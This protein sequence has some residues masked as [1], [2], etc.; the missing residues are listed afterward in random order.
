MD[1]GGRL[2][3]YGAG[4]MVAFGAAFAVA[5]AVAPGEAAATWAEKEEMNGHTEDAGTAAHDTADAPKGLSLS[6]DGFTLASIE[7]PAVVG[8]PGVLS[9]RIL[10]EDG[11]PVTSYA[12]AHDKELHL[13]VVR[14]DGDLFRH[15]HPELDEGTGA[16]SLPW[17]W[18]DAGTYRVYADFTPD[19]KGTY[20]LTLTRTVEVAGAFAP[21]RP[22]LTKTDEVD[23]YTV[24]LA[25]GLAAGAASELAITVSRDGAPVTAL[26]PYLGAFGH[27]VALREGDL[28]YLHVHAEGDDPQPGETSGPEIGFVAKPRRPDGTCC[29]SISRWTAPCTAPGSSS[30]RRTHRTP[31]TPAR[32]TMRTDPT[33]ARGGREE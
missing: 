13:I 33:R 19:E 14:S 10:G 4:L 24:S 5:G 28:A 25:G 6:T 11:A 12:T 27:L 30:R 23:G 1:T 3:L 18:T 22:A 26:E 32:T 2:A 9:F 17:T 16:W 21:A 31:R 29:T 20:G 15:V 7:A 8:E